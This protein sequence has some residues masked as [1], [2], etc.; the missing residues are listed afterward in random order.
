M[1]DA[2]LGGVDRFGHSTDQDS[3]TVKVYSQAGGIFIGEKP[4]VSLGAR[5]K[6][7]VLECDF[8]TIT[9]VC[10]SS[11]PAEARG[12]DMQVDSMQFNGNLLSEILG[13]SAPEAKRDRLAQDDRDGCPVCLGQTLDRERWTPA[14]EGT[15][16]GNCHHSRMA[17]QFRRADAL[18][19][20]RKHDHERS[21]E[22]S[23]GVKATP[24]SSTVKRRVKCTT[25]RHAG[26]RKVSVS[27]KT[28]TKDERDFNA[29]L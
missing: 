28:Y 3:K 11:M 2:S 8:R 20:R 19:R 7:N 16:A 6:F 29:S 14:T 27:I 21:H 17:G 26:S 15:D 9:R 5:D 13:G 22:G 25:R 12:L 10:R 24:G 18:D 1:S 4:I 23:K